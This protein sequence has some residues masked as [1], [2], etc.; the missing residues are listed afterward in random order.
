MTKTELAVLE[1]K[2]QEN[3]FPADLVIDESNFENY[4]FDVRRHRP[5]KGQI[6]A[7]FSAVVDFVEGQGKKDIIY[8]LKIGKVQQAVTVMQKIHGAMVPDCYRICR[9]ICED[10]LTLSEEE[11]EQKAYEYTMELLYYT[12]RELVPK[13]DV[14]WETIG[15][16]N[17]ETDVETGH[18]KY[19]IEI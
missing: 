5:K 1:P 10:L 4:F 19:K 14:H 17:M 15:L 7:K 12:Y 16:L 11:V 3:L 9:E 18:I 13:N 6:M 8:L 2:S